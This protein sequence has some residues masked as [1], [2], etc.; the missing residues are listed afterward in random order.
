MS[1][2]KWTPVL[3]SEQVQ[4]RKVEDIR[5][6]PHFV[7]KVRM[8]RSYMSGIRAVQTGPNLGMDLY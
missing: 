3:T 2:H 7:E 4:R 1:E 8:M 6:V 5:H